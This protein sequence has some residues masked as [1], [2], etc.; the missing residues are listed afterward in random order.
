MTLLKEKEDLIQS[1]ILQAA[2]ALF[3]QYGLQKVT[4]DD[5]AK[6][7]GKG[8]SSL[9]YYYKSKEEILDAV[10]DMEIL[11][12]LA[13]MKKAVDRAPT[14][15][16]KIRAFCIAKLRAARKRRELYR[17]AE[18]G[19]EADY[20]KTK[21]AVHKRYMQ[22][23]RDLLKQILK[24]S[25]DEGALRPLDEKELDLVVFVLVSSLYGL[26][27]EVVIDGDYTG[28]EPAVD[29]LSRLVMHGLK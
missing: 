22:Q 5:V 18:S 16:E 14:I 19:V 17:A 13:E 24:E 6:A 3:Q 11:E 1:Q 21:Q 4:M 26:K 15:E 12:M 27:R 25:M 29:A 2:Q 20:A 8:R 28:I 9:Y 10:M 23:Q 7:V